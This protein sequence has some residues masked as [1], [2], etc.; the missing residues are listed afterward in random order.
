MSVFGNILP[1][2]PL[3]FRV[4]ELLLCTEACLRRMGYS[5][6]AVLK[7][8]LWVGILTLLLGK[9]NRKCGWGKQIC[10]FFSHLKPVRGTGNKTS[11]E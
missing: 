11:D 3:L 10:E 6:R 7:N 8:Q 4:A 9:F 2:E 1:S 5:S